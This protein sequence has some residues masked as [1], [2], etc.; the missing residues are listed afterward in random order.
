[1]NSSSKTHDSSKDF[2]SF[3]PPLLVKELRQ[4]LRTN[5]FVFFLILFPLLMAVP[6]LIYV[7]AGAG[8]VEKSMINVFFWGCVI[9]FFL[10]LNPLRTL[11]AV[12]QEKVTR[13]NELMVMTSLSSSGIVWGKWISYTLQT[14]LLA[15]VIMPFLLLRYFLGGVELVPELVA[16]AGILVLTVVLTALGIWVSGMPVFYRILYSITVFLLVVAV[17]SLV[18]GNG[19][20]IFRGIGEESMLLCLSFAVLAGMLLFL[21][22]GILVLASQ[23]F[24]SPAENTACEFRRKILWMTV[25]VLAGNL[26]FWAVDRE[27]VKVS[28]ILVVLNCFYF[29]CLTMAFWVEMV[30][31]GDLLSA[32]VRK[33][34]EEGRFWRMSKALWLPGWQSAGLFYLLMMLL[35]CGVFVFLLSTESMLEKVETLVRGIFLIWADVTLVTIVLQALWKKWNVHS[36]ILFPLLLLFFLLVTALAKASL[37]GD[38]DL[39][40]LISIIP[41]GNLLTLDTNTDGVRICNW[42]FILLVLLGFQVAAHPYWKKYGEFSRKTGR[43]SVEEKKLPDDELVTGT[44]I[45]NSSDNVAEQE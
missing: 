38:V 33:I 3:V 23:W 28:T 35:F 9:L 34:K 19:W 37:G 6:F 39:D 29:F 36:L 5:G 11:S 32:H 26:V 21:C 42:I 1:M 17:P 18:L 27:L 2:P 12:S 40:I 22:R 43:S 44:K 10:I 7:L 14:L 16:M 8:I 15:L 30:L 31:P 13:S 20:E 45:K 4:G 24:A 41:A 25:A